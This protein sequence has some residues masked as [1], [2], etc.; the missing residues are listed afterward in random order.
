MPA[1]TRRACAGRARAQPRR[2]V[3][4]PLLFSR[5]LRR[6][7]RRRR[8]RLAAFTVVVVSSLACVCGCR[9]RKTPAVAVA[10]RRTTR[11]S[12]R[13]PRTAARLAAIGRPAEARRVS[14]SCDAGAGDGRAR[15]P[16]R[17]GS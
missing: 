6:R 12:P 5:R 9:A 7:R 13:P 17:R 4:L 8:R 2:L 16:S 10:R 1:A 11:W 14:D 3:P 15:S